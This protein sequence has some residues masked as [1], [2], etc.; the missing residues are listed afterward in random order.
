MM[1]SGSYITETS[2][3]AKFLHT[4]VL[5][6]NIMQDQKYTLRLEKNVNN[7]ARVFTGV[8][9]AIL[10]LKGLKKIKNPAGMIAARLLMG[11]ALLFISIAA[12][13]NATEMT[14]NLPSKE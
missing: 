12:F 7:P 11:S 9:G 10:I 4:L 14:R 13:S 5:K 8:M 2:N 1:R 6:L 3:K